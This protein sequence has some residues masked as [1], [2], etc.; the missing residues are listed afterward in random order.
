MWNSKG[1]KR[2][3]RREIEECWWK[4]RHY[5]VSSSSAAFRYLKVFHNPEQKQERKAGKA[6]RPVPNKY[7]KRFSRVNRDLI[8]DVQRRNPEKTA[9]L[10][11]DATLVE[12]RKK[13]ALFSYKGFK[14]YR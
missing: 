4:E 8:G 7:L 11:M 12:T 5:S 14:A 9:T 13:E 6:F 2:K 3:K 1:L 10:D